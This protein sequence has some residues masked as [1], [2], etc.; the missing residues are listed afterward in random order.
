M[1]TKLVAFKTP[2]AANSE[3]FHLRV[4]VT[5]LNSQQSDSLADHL[6]VAAFEWFKANGRIEN[7][8]ATNRTVE[9]LPN[10]PTRRKQ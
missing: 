7:L 5:P 8:E 6:R 3:L 9:T 4:F 10:D 2:T 1:K